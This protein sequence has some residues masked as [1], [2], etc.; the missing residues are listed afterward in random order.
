MGGWTF[1]V[2]S[3]CRD[4]FFKNIIFSFWWLK[5]TPPPKKTHT[6][7]HKS[8]KISDAFWRKLFPVIFKNLSVKF[9]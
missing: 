6:H 1:K 9:S 3:I 5:M 4:T 2:G 7:T 8:L